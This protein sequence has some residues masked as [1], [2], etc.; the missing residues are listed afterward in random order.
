[1]LRVADESSSA[2]EM[3]IVTFEQTNTTAVTSSSSDITEPKQAMTAKSSGVVG[4]ILEL[5]KRRQQLTGVFILS[6]L[7]QFSL[8]ISNHSIITHLYSVWRKKT[9]LNKCHY[10]PYTSI[11][12]YKIYGNYSRHNLPL[13]LQILSSHLSFFRSSTVLSIKN[14]FSTAQTNKSDY[15]QLMGIF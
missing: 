2:D 9:P 13:L 4:R 6:L 5:K 15:N 7:F 10:F 1:M 3:E 8:K 14:N 11:F 12:F